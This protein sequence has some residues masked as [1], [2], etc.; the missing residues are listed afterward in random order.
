MGCFGSQT[1]FY[2]GKKQSDHRSDSKNLLVLIFIH[3]DLMP[4][5]PNTLYHIY[6]QG[7]NK[8]YI[9]KEN[10]D[11]Q[12]FLTKTNGLIKPHAE[13]LSYCL[14]PN[15]YH[16]ILLT[17]SQSTSAIKVGALTLTRLSNGFRLLQSEYAQEFN[18]KYNRTGSLFRQRTKFKIVDNGD[19]NY[20]KNLLNYVLSNPLKDGL[21]KHL[22]DW[23]FSNY[24]DII[25]E[26]NGKLT[27][28]E[29]NTRHLSD[30]KRTN[31]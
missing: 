29:K 26:R 5:E 16:F 24:L 31:N 3:I 12:R 1:S 2:L 17:N 28:I 8:E 15:H 7:N 30:Y 14:M 19:P 18:K 25:G 20:P 23:P 4:I 10:S 6:N 13:I 9:F 27:S 22:N 21:V 11:Y